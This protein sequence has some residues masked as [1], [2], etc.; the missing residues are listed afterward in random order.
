LPVGRALITKPLNRRNVPDVSEST[1][2][3]ASQVQPSSRNVPSVLS[4][5]TRRIAWSLSICALLTFQVF[6][7]T[8]PT[9][10]TFVSSSFAKTKFGSSISLIVQQG[11]TTIV[12]FNPFAIRAG[13]IVNGT[14]EVHEAKCGGCR[15]CAN[16]LPKR[17]VWCQ[18]RDSNSQKPVSQP[19]YDS[20]S[21]TLA[22]WYT[23]EDLKLRVTEV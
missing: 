23:G 7:Q 22:L 17:K 10:D 21:H 3:T 6:A 18:R 9:A 4:L 13:A 8:P 2:Y 20:N 1:G 5:I 12:Q 19:G 11:S 15:S 16:N 14:G